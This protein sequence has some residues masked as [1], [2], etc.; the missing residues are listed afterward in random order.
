MNNT[1]DWPPEF[2]VLPDGTGIVK[3]DARPCGICGNNDFLL[4]QTSNGQRVQCKCA[5]VKRGEK[6]LG[7][8]DRTRWVLTKLDK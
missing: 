2:Y 4:V 7:S 1:N 5:K 3:A 8:L 6:I